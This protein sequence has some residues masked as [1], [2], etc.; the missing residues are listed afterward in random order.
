[1]SPD[2]SEDAPNDYLSLEQNFD[3]PTRRIPNLGH[4]L[5]FVSFTGALLIFLELMLAA[6][7]MAPGTVKNGVIVLPHPK[8]Q[9]ATLIATYLTTLAAASLIFPHLWQRS[10][11]DGIE[12]RWTVART[13][14]GSLIGLGLLLGVAV[15]VLTY[16]ITPPKTL[17]VDDFLRTQSDAWLITL[18]GTILAPLFEEIC[19]RGFLLPA[20]A[21]AFDWLR[22][23]RTEEARARWQSTTTLTPAAWIVS[24]LLTSAV[25][26]MMHRQQVAH[27]WAAL[28]V[29]FSISL[30]LTL[31]RVKNRSVA[32]SFLVHAAYNGFIFLLVLFQTGGY[33]HLERMTR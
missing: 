20:I 22:L 17:P 23:P 19:F 11:I 33:R 6:M 8:L 7:G 13:R 4:A 32:A 12:W 30:V 5:A 2:R 31:V 18:F 21:I 1:M 9:I 25:F 29:L 3:A 14:A 10:F 16:F 26:A 15:Q 24:A 28:L 27:L